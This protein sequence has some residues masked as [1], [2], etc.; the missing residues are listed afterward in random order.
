MKEGHQRG[1]SP[2]F[3]GH[4]D[5]RLVSQGVWRHPSVLNAIRSIG[6]REPSVVGSPP[7]EPVKEPVYFRVQNQ[8]VSLMP[9][10]A[11]HFG[12]QPSVEHLTWRSRD[13]SFKP[14]FKRVRGLPH[15]FFSFFPFLTLKYCSNWSRRWFQNRSYSC[16]H[17]ATCRSGSPRN[18]MRTSRPCFR[19]SMSPA[20]SRSFR[21]LVT[22]LRAVSK[23]LATSRNRAGPLASWSIVDRREG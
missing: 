1:F 21:C 16:T 8:F 20:L 4:R 6:L 22:E 12:I 19:R 9:G 18:E 15:R 17:P 5:H 11:R 7:D 10:S 23:G 3:K 2:F 14:E 13:C